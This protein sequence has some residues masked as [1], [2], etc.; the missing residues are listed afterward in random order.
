MNYF[1]RPNTKPG[2]LEIF[3]SR[4]FEIRQDESSKILH[5]YSDR[6]PIIIDTVNATFELDK[7]K[8]LVPRDLTVAQFLYVIRKRCKLAP[9][10]GLFL[11]VNN[12]LLSSGV[13]ISQVYRNQADNDGF[14]YIIV[15]EESVF[16]GLYN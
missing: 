8:Y 9:E 3:K 2:Y 13:L 5:K 4:P 6:V 15:S 16:G 12:T 14:L 10:K 11:F 1:T 7:Y